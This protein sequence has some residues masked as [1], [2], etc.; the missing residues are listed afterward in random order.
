ML[1]IKYL[2]K[3]YLNFIYF[4]SNYFSIFLFIDILLIY[5]LIVKNGYFINLI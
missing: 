4:L 2:D 1:F 3:I 5:K